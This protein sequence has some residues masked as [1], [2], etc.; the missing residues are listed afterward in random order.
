MSSTNTTTRLLLIRHGINDFVVSHRMA[1]WLPGVHLNQQG[2][3][4][5][6]A[7]GRRLSETPIAAIYSSPLERTLETAEAIRGARPLSVTSLDE[8]GE[9]HCGEWTGQYVNDALRETALWHEI[10][11]FPSGARFPGGE[12]IFEMQ[13]RMVA[14]IER[15]RAAHSGETFVVVSHAD[16]IR[17][18]IA[19]YLGLHLDLFHR[20]I[21]D[22]ASITEL[23]F[24]A[25]RPQLVRCNDIAHHSLGVPAQLS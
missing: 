8:I 2:C 1:G 11:R 17:V 25:V 21:V 14:A 13:A 16:P 12:S 15:L 6:A 5:V 18:A 19:H 7:L 9:T 4:Q 22:P 23:E 10:Q 3:E 24:N 20:I